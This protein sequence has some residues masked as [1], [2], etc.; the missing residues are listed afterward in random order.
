MQV[1]PTAQVDL[2]QSCPFCRPPPTCPRLSLQGHGGW[3]QLGGGRHSGPQGQQPPPQLTAEQRARAEANR[4]EALRRQGER[5]QASQASAAPSSSFMVAQGDTASSRPASALRGVFLASAHQQSPAPGWQPGH[6]QQRQHYEQLAQ[7]PQQ[8]AWAP[9]APTSH[10]PYGGWQ[11][12][13]PAALQ[14]APS[15]FPQQRQH[16]P[17]TGP[18]SSSTPMSAGRGFTFQPPPGGCWLLAHLTYRIAWS[19]CPTEHHSSHVGLPGLHAGLI[20]STAPEAAQQQQLQQLRPS[21]DGAAF[22]RKHRADTLPA[23]PALPSLPVQQGPAFSSAAM[24][25]WQTGG[26]A[27]AGTGPGLP[28]V[29]AVAQDGGQWARGP[30]AP[31]K[32][33]LQGGS[34]PRGGGKATSASNISWT[35]DPTPQPQKPMAQATLQQALSRHAKAAA[36][37][38]E[39]AAAASAAGAAPAVPDAAFVGH[40]RQQQEA[41]QE[42][43][44]PLL[45]GL[46]QQQ[47]RWQQ[48]GLTA[49]ETPPVRAAAASSAATST[50]GGQGGSQAGGRRLGLGLPLLAGITGGGSGSAALSQQQAMGRPP[51]PPARASST[52]LAGPGPLWGPLMPGAPAT[53]AQAQAPSR[54]GRH[55]RMQRLLCADANPFT[56]AASSGR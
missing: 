41:A 1:R 18:Y 26:A 31:G 25:Q 24:G 20:P 17:S 12:P 6:V 39:H 45:A 51:L 34:R 21:P 33:P 3:G 50:W 52:P 13:L 5:R 37:R 46:Q 2:Q 43:A 38:Q 4:Q 22:V 49:A 23:V 29:A 9:P 28:Q 47:P 42:Q 7:P 48:P 32:P 15:P 19:H 36:E 10:T 35:F 44:L 14:A 8:Q 30:A 11:Q 54:E 53:S 16:P 40:R 56:A 55:L 27:V